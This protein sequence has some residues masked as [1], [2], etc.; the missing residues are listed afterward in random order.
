MIV[1]SSIGGF[2]AKESD[3]ILKVKNLLIN[4]TQRWKGRY[5]A[6]WPVLKIKF[7]QIMGWFK[8]FVRLDFS[9]TTP[10]HPTKILSPIDICT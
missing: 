4:S 10:M 1:V 8:A 3:M 5:L 2:E 7:S 9:Y 6:L